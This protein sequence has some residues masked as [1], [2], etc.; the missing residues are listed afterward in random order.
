MMLDDIVHIYNTRQ[1]GELPG[2][3][4]SPARRALVAVSRRCEDKRPTVSVWIG[5]ATEAELHTL[6]R[7]HYD[8]LKKTWVR[9]V[10]H[11][12]LRYAGY[13]LGQYWHFLTPRTPAEAYVWHEGIVPNRYGVVFT[14]NAVS[15]FVQGC[16]RFAAG[17]LGV[18]FR[19]YF[20]LL[21]GSGLAVVAWQRRGIWRHAC[22][23]M[24]LAASG[25]LYILSYIPV[26]A[27]YDFR[28]SYW[29]CL[30][31]GVAAIVALT[32]NGRE[33]SR[34]VVRPKA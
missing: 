34:K 1:I 24:A 3:K 22:Y 12:P 26:V 32:D 8:E 14:G 4:D 31:I 10:T 11:H 33:R 30:A 28:Y 7:G 17:D 20:W 29:S 6:T 9:A 18:L 16:V 13:R 25:V 21:A 23:I 19:P 15:G 27:A 5:C 2:A